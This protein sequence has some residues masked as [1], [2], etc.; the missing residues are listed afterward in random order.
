LLPF[1]AHAEIYKWI[2]SSGRIHFSD[3]AIAGSQ[4]QHIQ[5]MNGIANPAFNLTRTAMQIPYHN[6]NGSMIVQGKVN[7][8][9]MDFIVDTGASLVIIPPSIAKKAHISTTNAKPISL[10][11]ANGT[12]Q[13]YE[14]SIANLQINKLQQQHVRAAIQQ[15]SSDPN[16]G[17]LGMSFLHAY[18][19]RIDHLHHTISLEAQLK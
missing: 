14:V 13:S 10:Q 18:T 11:T 19:M 15:V 16:L 7:G 4:K 8:I 12:A 2:D 9:A 6:S 1:V 3:K 5:R 17:L